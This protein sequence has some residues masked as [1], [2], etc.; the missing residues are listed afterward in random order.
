M[1]RPFRR[2]AGLRALLFVLVLAAIGARLVLSP[3][4]SRAPEALSEGEYVVARVIDG[5]TFEL[6]GGA[7]VR[8][9]GVDTPETKHPDLPPEPYGAEAAEFTRAFLSGGTVRLRFDKERSDKYGRHLAYAYVGERMLNEELVRAGLATAELGFRYSESMKRRFRRA[10][11][12]AQAAE[13]GI[14]EAASAR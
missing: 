2:R 13:R 6:A 7:V 8:L 10:Q 1:A 14:W 11:E 12:D 4:R 5:D 3:P 9:Q